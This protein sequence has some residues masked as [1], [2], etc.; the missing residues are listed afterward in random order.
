MNLWQRMKAAILNRTQP[1]EQRIYL[2]QRQGGVYVSEDSALTYS[3]V[4]ACVRVISETIAALPWHVYRKTPSG[5]EDAENSLAWLLDNQPCAEMTAV[6][7]R[8]A[9]VAHALLWGNGYAEIERDNA[10]RV[11]AL[12]LLTPDRV[13]VKRDDAGAL[14][15][16]LRLDDSTIRKLAPSHVFHLHGLGFDGLVGYSPVRMAARSIGL[17]IAQDSFGQ[18]FYGNGTTFGGMVEVPGSMTPQ[19]I[20]DMEGYLNGKHGGPDKA[21]R[22]RVMAAGMKYTNAGMPMTD[23][24]FIESRRFSVNEIARWYRVPPHKIA[25]LER[26]TNNNIEHQSIEFVTDTLLPWLRRLEKEANTK[27]IGSR[28]QGN[29]YTKFNVNALMRGDA[30]SRAEFYRTMTQIGAMSINE[31]RALEELNGIGDDGDAMLVQ[32]NQ[33]TL[34]RL[35]EGEPMAAP[36]APVAEEPEEDDEEPEDEAP[37]NVIR[38]AALAFIRKQA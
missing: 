19:Q 15:Y 32:L 23:A 9:I 1:G 20:A 18:A 22:V 6:S 30:K 35:V 28:A 33:T 16:E 36:A 21:F 37:T 2:P 5:R 17:G 24:Q 7:F 14:Y 10:G 38:S 26:S 3:A 27:L 25:D 11:A 4:W 12:W 31:V 8:E 29:V 13:E 34:E